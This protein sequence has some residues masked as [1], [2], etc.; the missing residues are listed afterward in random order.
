MPSDG[1]GN[2]TPTPSFPGSGS[3]PSNPGGAMPG[4]G[5]QTCLDFGQCLVACGQADQACQ[6]ACVGRFPQEAVQQYTAISICAQRSMCAQGDQNCLMTNCGCEIGV[7][8]GTQ[9]GPCAGANDGGCSSIFQCL[10]TCRD[11][12]CAMNCFQRGNPEGQ[13]LYQAFQQCLQMNGCVAPTGMVDQ[14]CLQAN[15]TNQLNACIA[16]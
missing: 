14:M 4:A 16:N 13:Q 6:Q 9:A 15:C 10:Q 11:Q 7:C 2:N 8:Q 12:G 3:P 5:G 1:N